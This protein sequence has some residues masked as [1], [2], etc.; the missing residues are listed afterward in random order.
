M[1]GY[2]W[3]QEWGLKG[4]QGGHYIFLF[5]IIWRDDRGWGTGGGDNA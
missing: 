4:S 5:Q 2:R 3:S 1:F